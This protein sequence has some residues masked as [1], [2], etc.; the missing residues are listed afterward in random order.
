MQ[1]EKHIPRSNLWGRVGPMPCV[2]WKGTQ[3]SLSLA[4]AQQGQCGIAKS[5]VPCM[6]AGFGWRGQGGC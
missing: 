5:P 4:A 2:L 1:V 3:A 6:E